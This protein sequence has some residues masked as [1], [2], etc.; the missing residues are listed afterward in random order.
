MAGSSMPEKEIVDRLLRRG[1]ELFE[2]RKRELVHFTGEPAADT[3]LNDIEGRPHAFLLACILDRQ[4]VAE[5][6]WK[7]PLEL[8][9]R[10]GSF[11]FQALEN[12]TLV[13][14]QRA[15]TVPT[16]LHRFSQQMA[17]HLYSAIRR[18]REQ[19]GGDASKIWENKPSSYAVVYRFLEFDGVGVKIA[20]MAAN[21]LARDFKIPMVEYRA[22]DV[23][24]DRHVLRV[25]RRLGLIPIS[26]SIDHLLYRARELSSNFP[27]LFD[28]P[29]F[30]IGRTW[31]KPRTPVCSDCYMRDICPSGGIRASKSKDS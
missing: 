26:G 18:I 4:V 7:I 31:C 20:S 30:E 21:I 15:M 27:G 10:I 8:Q 17:A 12:L 11:D 23:S 14:V 6:A 25:F 2:A 1:Q 24:P 13:E 28:Y 29:T 5:R 19:Y 22:I 9:R 16:H 3:L